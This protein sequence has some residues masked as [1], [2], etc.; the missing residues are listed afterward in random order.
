[1]FC[2]KICQ[3]EAI[4]SANDFFHR[5]I[6]SQVSLKFKDAVEKIGGLKFFVRQQTP[7]FFDSYHLLGHLISRTGPIKVLSFEVCGCRKIWGVSYIYVKQEVLK[8]K[9][10]EY[11]I[12]SLLPNSIFCP[13]ANRARE[14]ISFQLP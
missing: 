1:M 4:S 5:P 3:D 10:G 7:L 13:S 12:F 14:C 2:K 6:F 8:Q 11:K 9:I